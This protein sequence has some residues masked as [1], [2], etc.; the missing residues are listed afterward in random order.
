MRSSHGWMKVRFMVTSNILF[1]GFSGDSVQWFRAEAEIIRWREQAEKKQAKFLRTITSFSRMAEIWADLAKMSS[2]AGSTT[3]EK[4]KA[5]MFRRME[6]EC[7]GKLIAAGY[8][9]LLTKGDMTIAEYI[10]AQRSAEGE[11]EKQNNS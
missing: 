7:Q 6:A 4:K 1:Y 2:R 5:D 10:Q 3:Y 11:L 8:G 9:T